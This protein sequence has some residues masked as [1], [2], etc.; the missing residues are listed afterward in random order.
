MSLTLHGIGIGGGIAIGHAHLMS[1]T[2]IE[3]AQYLLDDAEVPAELTRFDDAIRITRK[4]LEM[5]WGSIPENAPT[6]LGAFL[7]LHLMLLND[8]TLS[9]EPR[10]LIETQRCNAEWALKQQL[11]TLLAQ[12]DEIEEEY[13]RERRTDVIQVAERIFKALAGHDPAAHLLVSQARDS[14]LVAHD[15]SPA[16]MVLFKDTSYV[17]FV[18]DVGGPTSHTAILA[19]SLDLPSVL[20]L[21]HA[22]GLI[23]EG[24]MVIVDGVNGFVIVDPDELILAEYR[25]RQQEW[26]LKQSALQDIR[27]SVP[28]TRDG[29]EVELFANIELPEDTTLA[30]ANGATGVGLF[31]SE[32]LFLKEEALPGEE[33][34]FEAYKA[35]AENM[36]G[37]PVIIRTVDLGKDK[38]ATWQEDTDAPNPALGLT[39][40]RLC[41]AEPSMFRTQLHALLRAS[42]FGKI[43]LLIPMISTIAE[44]KQTRRHLE[45]VKAQLRAEGI[46][47]DEAIEL[48]GM[49]EVPAAALTVRGLLKHLD[50]ISIGTNDLIQYSLAVD[51]N[52]DAVSHLYDP[53]HPA[54]VKLLSL[55][56]DT[57]NA[58]GKP[59]SMCGEMAGDPALTRLLLGLGLRRFSMLPAQLLKVKQQV[60]GTDVAA[61]SPLIEAMCETSDSDELRAL[62]AQLDS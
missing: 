31:R 20:A 38:I 39:G 2:D 12:F 27:A 42:A 24:E 7:S 9:K 40:I 59:V 46:A 4:E 35:V 37:M 26:L 28:V 61:L 13:L 5:L 19:R 10:E 6:E 22:R 23:R 36:A 41:M 29:V 43:K 15:L 48:G 18:T 1:H 54:V 44:V 56:I 47:F 30:L 3:I 16:D 33:E 45:E 8:H 17:A 51:R 14:I 50:F 34:Q 32:F 60:L 58:V 21:K 25:T 52:D 11:D 62:A 57:A 53:L 55:I 49:I